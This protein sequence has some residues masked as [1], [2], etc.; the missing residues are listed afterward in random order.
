MK[1]TRMIFEYWKIWMR[2]PIETNIQSLNDD[3]EGLGYHR[4][5]EQDWVIMSFFYALNHEWYKMNNKKYAY[6]G[7]DEEYEEPIDF[8]YW[9]P[10]WR[11]NETH[12]N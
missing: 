11:R 8:L 9:Q 12:G 7:C 2:V 3:K 10:Y 6:T 5:Y 1:L 4:A